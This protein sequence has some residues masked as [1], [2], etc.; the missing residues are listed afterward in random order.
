MGSIVCNSLCG[1]AI[2]TD[3]ESHY[4]DEVSEFQTFYSM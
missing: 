2:S 4:S 3:Y 1:E